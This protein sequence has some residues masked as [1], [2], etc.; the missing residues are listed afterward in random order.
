MTAPAPPPAGAARV[1]ALPDPR[2]TEALAA[3]LAGLLRPG[4]VVALTGELGAGK[5]VFARALIRR[6]ARNAGADAGEVPS[7]TYTLVQPYELP[8]LTAYHFDLYRLSAADEAL[9][10]GIEDAF[11]DGISV[12]EWAERIAPLLPARC[13]RVRLDFGA[14]ETE[15][16]ASLSGPFPRGAA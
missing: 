13:F 4:D 3:G 2:A 1:E 8:G 7:P 12:I 6:L 5:T 9:E 11:A 14:G 16:V 10:L 15:R